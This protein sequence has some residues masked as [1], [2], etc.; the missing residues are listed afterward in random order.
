MTKENSVKISEL[1]KE[2]EDYIMKTTL[3]QGDCLYVPVHSW[4]AFQSK[5]ELSQFM[6]FTYDASSKL[7]DLMFEAIQ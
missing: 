7:T 3:K 2:I 6:Q 5:S 1:Q 4:L